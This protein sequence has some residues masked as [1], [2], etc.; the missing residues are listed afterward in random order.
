M[1]DEPIRQSPSDIPFLSQKDFTLNDVMRE[2]REV[3]GDVVELKSAV[4]G[5]GRPMEGLAV[6][7]TLIEKS[8][9]PGG[10]WREWRRWVDWRFWIHVLL[11]VVILVLAIINLLLTLFGGRT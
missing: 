4:T 10:D 7:T 2:L 11:S 1:P 3:R 5:N 6:R 8:M 9:A